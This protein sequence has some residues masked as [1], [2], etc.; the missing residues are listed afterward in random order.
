MIGAILATFLVGLASP[1]APVD[2][3][4]LAA[5][6]LHADHPNLFHDLQPAR[7]DTA[8]ADLAARA[9]SL[10]EDELLVGLMRLAALPGV[11]DGHTGIFPLNPANQRV[12]HAYPLRM[13]TFSDGTYV[14]GQAGGSD[15]L[16]A[17]VVAVNGR[18][19]EDVLAAVKPLVPRDNDSTRG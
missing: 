19:L 4:H 3:V 1:T 12:L 9:E 8:V 10:N 13:Y 5:H 7:F 14:V 15:L 11:R 18:P 2:D 17:K 16:R 6:H